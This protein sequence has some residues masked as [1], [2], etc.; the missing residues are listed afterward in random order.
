MIREQP[1]HVKN[2]IIL[3]KALKDRFF[4]AAHIYLPSYVVEIAVLSLWQDPGSWHL[5]LDASLC[6]VFELLRDLD[7][8]YVCVLSSRAASYSVTQESVRSYWQ[9]S[10][11]MRSGALV[12]DPVNP[13]M[14]VARLVDVAAVRERSQAVLHKVWGA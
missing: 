14:N 7:S 4:R 11:S 8:T 10:Q 12:V 1:Q 5:D 9:G 6:K 13:L 3:A 2:V